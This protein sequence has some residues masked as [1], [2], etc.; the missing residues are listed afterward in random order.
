[1]ASTKLMAVLFLIY[2]VALGLG[3]FIENEYNTDTARLVIYNTH[4][5]EFIMLVFVI[6]FIANIKRYQLHKKEKFATLL[7]HLSF[8]LIIAGAAITRYISFEGMMPIREGEQ[9]NQIYSDHTFVTVLVDG[10]INGQM[11][12]LTFSDKALFSAALTKDNLVSKF[13]SNKY[14][15]KKSFNNIPFEISYKNYLMGAKEVVKPNPKGKLQLKLVESADGQRHEH[16]IEQ[17]TLVSIHNMLYAF[18]KPTQGAINFREENG[19]YFIQ[20]PISGNYM[21]MAT[22]TS[23]EITYNQEEPLHFRAMYQIAGAQFVLDTPV[24][25]DKVLAESTNYKDTKAENALTLTVSSQGK[26]QD[27][28]LKAP[29]GAMGIPQSIKLGDLEF[30]LIYGSKIYTTPFMVK[31]NDF[32]ADKHPGTQN[33]Y[34]SF[35]SKVTV[36]APEETFD[37]RIYMNHILDYKGYRF[38]QAQFDQDEKG[39]ILSVNHDF[40]GT[41]LTYIGYGLLYLGLILILFTKNTR[42]YELRTKLDKIRKKKSALSLIG[43]L[44]ASTLVYSQ[45]QH[46]DNPITPEKLDSL[47]REV[48]VP[49]EHAARFGSLV[50]QDANGRMKPLNT[51]TSELLRKVSE[52]ETYKGLNSDQVFLSMRQYQM[53]WHNAPIIKLKRGNDSLRLAIGLPKSAKFASFLNFFD[54]KGNYK[55]TKQVEQANH[56]KIQNKFEID[57]IEIDK[58]IYLLSQALSGSLLKIFPIPNS[59]NNRWI[60]TIELQDSGLKAMDSIYVQNI[61]PLYYK[62]LYDASQSKDYKN[63]NE[64]LNSIHNYQKKYGK[65]VIPTDQH[66]KL[67]ILYN[68]YDIF[69]KLFSWYIYASILL[70]VVCIVQ[71]FKSSKFLKIAAKTLTIAIIILFALHTLGLIARWYI[72]GHAPWSDAYESIIYVGWATMLFGLYFGRKSELTIASTAFVAGLLLMIAH[73]NWMDPAIA[74]LQ[75]VLDSYWLMIHVAIIVGSYGPFSLGM[76]LGIIALLLMILTNKKNKKKMRL[77]LDEI[78][79]INEMALTVGLVMLTIGNFLGGQWANESWGRYWGWDPKE[80][81]A[82][83]SIMVYAFV[84]HMRFVPALRGKWF[85]NLMSVLAIYAVLM[86]Y[87]GVNFYLSGLHSYAQGDQ[88][89]TPS[90]VWVSLASVTTLG[91]LSYFKY[92]KYY[93]K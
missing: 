43:F 62:A 52:S 70:L 81:W 68:Q 57:F 83:V 13:S 58:R 71:I 2:A 38:F 87:F 79:Y 40:W 16:Y 35:E 76:I 84:I 51:F 36:I 46:T 93:K 37:A 42:F 82:L 26:T 15:L 53:L 11:R 33:S 10:E 27:V 50:I 74:N 22:Q 5:F 34:K 29:K 56:A 25:G 85:Y 20:S 28:T 14:H 8:I 73:W 61:L 59:S 72:S 67:E 77:S 41:W 92:K 78:T 12:R 6:N 44:L 19:K 60:S 63:A 45:H 88:M 18:N 30:T 47:I 1:M 9:S 64:L 80:T 24:L 91:I 49:K 86:T 48:A 54:E 21:V 23:G 7:L 90:F 89:V 75:P 4:W 32:I 69:K 3:T 65:Q 31:L 55:L 39:T 17:G 66:I